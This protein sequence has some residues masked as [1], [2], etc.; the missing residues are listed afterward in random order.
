MTLKTLNGEIGG[1]C[2]YVQVI[3]INKKKIKLLNDCVM[4]FGF[5]KRKAENISYQFTDISSFLI[6]LL[7]TRDRRKITLFTFIMVL[8]WR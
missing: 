8:G 3:A 2:T 4:P 5:R 1:K 6:N 7:N